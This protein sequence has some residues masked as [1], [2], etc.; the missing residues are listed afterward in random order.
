MADHTFDALFRSLAK[1]ELSPVYYLYGPEDVL[2]DEALRSILDRALDPAM[3]DFNL[4]QRSAGQLDPEQLHALCNTLPMMADRRVVVIREVEIWRRKSKA[5]S[6]FL[7][8][9]ERPSPQTVVVL[10]QGSGEEDEDKELARGSY[11]VRLDSLPADRA[12]KWLL[13]R[14]GSLGVNLEPAAAEHL[15]YSVGPELGAL[16][17]ELAKL[18]SL[19][20]DQPLTPDQVGELIGVRRGETQWDW[21]NAVLEDQ[22][23]RAVS[24]LASI[25]D[26]SGMSGVKLVTLL[27]TTF[28][29]LGVSR[30]LYDKG[31]RGRNLEDGIFRALLRSRPAGLLGYKEEAARWSQLLSRWS[32]SR[33]DAAIAACLTADQALKSTTISGELGVLTDLVLSIGLRSAEAA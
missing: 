15:V 25:L 19:P 8:Y 21:R 14:A 7:R 13:R 17:S 2:K 1:G 33:I 30:R 31:Q 24:L 5:R 4:D 27:G 12:A 29:G 16:S 6:E 32:A 11:T 9:L 20:E 3:R 10:I 22:S 28:I 18:A 23:G 26:Q